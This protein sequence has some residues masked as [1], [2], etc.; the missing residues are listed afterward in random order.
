LVLEPNDGTAQFSADASFR[1]ST[2]LGGATSFEASN[3]KGYFVRHR[4]F[5]M[6]VEKSDDSPQF[7]ADSS[8]NVVHDFNPMIADD[9]SGR[10]CLTTDQSS[11]YPAPGDSQGKVAPLIEEG[12]LV[13]MDGHQDSW[14]RITGASVP[15]GEG[16][17]YWYQNLECR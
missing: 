10:N 13:T 8:F 1:V 3:F 11:V 16:W 5:S 2:G 15:N 17:I 6:Y 14:V 4:D 7:H 12:Q 9:G